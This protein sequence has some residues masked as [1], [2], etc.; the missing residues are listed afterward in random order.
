MLAGTSTE[1]TRFSERDILQRQLEFGRIEFDRQFRMDMTAGAGQQHPLKLRDLIVFE[2]TP[3]SPATG[4]KL[5]L[6]SHIQWAPLRDHRLRDLQVD[7]LP[8]DGYLY[9]PQMMDIM[10]PAEETICQIDTSGEGEDETTWSILAGLSGRVYFCKQ[11]ASKDGHSEATMKAIA[12][13][14]AAWGVQLVKIRGVPVLVT[15]VSNAQRLLRRLRAGRHGDDLANLAGFLQADRL[16][17]GDFVERV[18]AHFYVGE[19]DAGAVGLD[20]RLH[21]VVDHALHAD[22]GLHRFKPFALP[23]CIAALLPFT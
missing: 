9:G 15:V 7:S 12:Q 6:P 21:I 3:P 13:D 4:G 19:I 8:G 1:P 22:Q 17:D 20:P 10:L 2:F 16:L 14:C 11:G 5:I 18:H 23:C